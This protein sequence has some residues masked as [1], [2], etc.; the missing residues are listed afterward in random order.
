LRPTIESISQFAIWL[1]EKDRPSL[2]DAGRT[3]IREF[4]DKLLANWSDSTARN[5]YS[6]LR[7]FYRR[8]VARTRSAT[9]RWPR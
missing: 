4:I 6:D 3:E 9:R 7:Q 2:G 1:E 5:R 8:L